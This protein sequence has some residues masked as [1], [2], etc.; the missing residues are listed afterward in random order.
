LF[1]MVRDP[2][3]FVNGNYYI[4]NTDHGQAS[5]VLLC[6]SARTLLAVDNEQTQLGMRGGSGHVTKE[7]SMS[8]C[9]D[10]AKSFALNFKIDPSGINSNALL[11]FF[12]KTIEQ[13]SRLKIQ[14]F[15]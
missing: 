5:N 12:L 9:I 14:A 4:T 2:V 7:L 11:A 10:Y 15:I 3:H 8:G 13:E 6:L 1:L